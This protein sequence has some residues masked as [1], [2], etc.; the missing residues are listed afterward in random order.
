MHVLG[1]NVETETPETISSEQASE[2]KIS[3]KTFLQRWLG[4]QR[5][6]PSL[7]PKYIL[8]LTRATLSVNFI[9]LSKSTLPVWKRVARTP[10]FAALVTRNEEALHVFVDALSNDWLPR[11]CVDE[12]RKCTVK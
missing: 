11:S 6:P 8:L 2:R 5:Y 3:E 10:L 4:W 12:I 9:F 7:H 1:A